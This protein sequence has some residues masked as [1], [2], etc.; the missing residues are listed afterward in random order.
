MKHI[1][2]YFMTPKV[3]LFLMNVSVFG[4]VLNGRSHKLK[5]AKIFKLTDVLAQVSVVQRE[6]LAV[7]IKF[8]FNS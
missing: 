4:K 5:I 1:H 2:D 7:L 3:S 8:K 6:T